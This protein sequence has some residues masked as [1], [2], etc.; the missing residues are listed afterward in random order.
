MLVNETPV[1]KVLDE[2]VQNKILDDEM[3]GCI[4]LHPTRMGR[5]R[6][7]MGILPRR[8]PEAFHAFCC[9]LLS[10][11]RG[12]LVK[13]L[14]NPDTEDVDMGFPEQSMKV[15]TNPDTEDME[16]CFPEHSSFHLGGDLYLIAEQDGIL[17]TDKNT[18]SD[19]YFPLV[20]WVQLQTTWGYIDDAVHYLEHNRYTSLDVL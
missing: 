11:K 16:M 1:G 12:D 15:L 7:L 2:L 8:G 19:I 17:L 14:T 4:C 9:A 10:L 5:A 13:V 20:R 6:A 18:M 3:R